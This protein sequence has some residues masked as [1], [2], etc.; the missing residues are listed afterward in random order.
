MH[1]RW[2]LIAVLLLAGCNGASSERAAARELCAKGGSDPQNSEIACTTIINDPGTSTPEQVV[3]LQYR[4]SARAQLGKRDGMMADVNRAA[5]LKPDDPALLTMRGNLH[6]IHGDLE[7]AQRDFE[8]A[9]RLDPD[10]AVALANLGTLYERKD[11]PELALPHLERALEL[12][13]AN[14]NARGARCWVLTVLNRDL[15]RALSDCSRALKANPQDYNSFNSRGFLHFRLGQYEQSIA[16]YD[17]AIAGDATMA[18]SFYM[19]GMAKRALGRSAEA[20]VDI[21][22]G[23]QLNSGVATRYASFGVAAP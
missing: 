9:I 5:A 12:D 20:E 22:K 18:S 15:P 21:A 3:S 6:G 4:A 10:N 23:L 11:Q 2:P 13:P 1:H 7:S 19:R 14:P 17:R 16:D 8:A